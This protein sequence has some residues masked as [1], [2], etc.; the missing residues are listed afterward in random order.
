[1]TCLDLHLSVICDAFDE[2]SG[3]R[4]D[5]FLVPLAKHA[6]EFRVG[7]DPVPRE[8]LAFR[9][10]EPGTVDEFEQNA[11]PYLRERRVLE[12]GEFLGREV[13][14]AEYVHE[15][16]RPFGHRDVL[17]G[18]FLERLALDEVLAETLQ[19]GEVL[20][21]ARGGELLLHLQVPHEGLH[22]HLGEGG[23]CRSAFDVRSVVTQVREE[24]LER[25]SVRVYGAR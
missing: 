7:I 23:K 19:G 22:V 16:L 17:C 11:R 12:F 24:L 21:N 10:A 9:D 25:L 20:A 3:E 1:M 6:H 2:T 4:H 13:L 5:A 8:H 14:L 15:P 18:I